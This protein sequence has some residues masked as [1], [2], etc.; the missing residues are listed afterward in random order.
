MAEFEATQQEIQNV[1]DPEQNAVTIVDPVTP[2]QKA[3][4]TAAGELRVIVTGGGSAGQLVEDADAV[5]G[6]DVGRIFVGS[7]GSNYRFVT[8]DIDGHLQVDVL[9]LPNVTLA[10]QAN[11][12]TNDI[13][14][15]LDGEL[16]DIS[17]RATRDLGK[18][19]IA[20]FDVSLPAGTN[21]IGD[22]D[23]ASDPPLLHGTDSVRLGDGTTLVNV[24]ND[25][26]TGRLQVEAKIAAGGAS[27]DVRLVDDQG[28]ALA[29]TE[30]EDL[31]TNG[32]NFGIPIAGR[33][34]ADLGRLVTVTNDTEDGKNRLE[35]S[36]KISVSSPPPP[37]AATAVQVAGD[38][39]LNVSGTED[40]DYEITN[41]TTF[42]VQSIAAGSEGD[43]TEKGAKVEV[44]YVDS[45]ST[46]HIISR[47]YLTGQTV[48]IFPD[49]SAARDGTSLDGTAAGGT[50]LIRIRRLQFGGG[51]RELEGV[52][53]GFEL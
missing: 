3:L 18:I 21:N 39:P 46:E 17:D 31:I 51:S 36:G 41:G 16:V 2:T 30:A 11:P 48:Q 12:F 15:S 42:T 29:I 9:T 35:V 14:I 37:P 53:R 24:L 47:I 32:K 23:I 4:V 49:V 6:G 45:G 27:Q 7:D 44:I 40:T 22:V 20:A 13:N 1:I 19:D 5:A 34:L 8:T 38:T 25:S 10:S 50:G 28:D 26:G 43:P 33:D 52:V